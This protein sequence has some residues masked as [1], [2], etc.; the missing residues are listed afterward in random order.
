VKA[1]HQLPVPVAPHRV[2]NPQSISTPVYVSQANMLPTLDS[3]IENIINESWVENVLEK[4]YSQCYW[5]QMEDAAKFLEQAQ[6]TLSLPVMLSPIADTPENLTMM[7]SPV[8]TVAE[9]MHTTFCEAPLEP[10]TVGTSEPL[11]VLIPVTAMKVP[12][13]PIPL[14]FCHDES[15]FEVELDETEVDKSVTGGQDKC[16]EMITEIINSKI[17]TLPTS[18]CKSCE[19][20][21]VTCKSCFSEWQSSWREGWILRMDKLSDS[22]KMQEG[23]E[24]GQDRMVQLTAGL[25]TNFKPDRLPDGP[26]INCRLVDGPCGRCLERF[27]AKLQSDRIINSNQKVLVSVPKII[28]LEVLPGCVVSDPRKS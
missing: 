5:P 24:K 27:L 12:W 26:C 10:G 15:D 11:P 19:L 25:L 20:S 4:A 28:P 3:G 6:S 21:T 18:H 16:M 1:L 13:K 8:Q 2:G 23:Y 22:D 17:A 9:I 7:R 14:V